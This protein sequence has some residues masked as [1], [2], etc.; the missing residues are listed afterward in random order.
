MNVQEREPMKILD[1][2]V[3]ADTIETAP[4]DGYRTFAPTGRT[5]L[6]LTIEHDNGTVDH[7][8]AENPTITTLVSA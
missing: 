7:I 6:D 2:T 3:K 4:S 1:Y 8:F 5:T